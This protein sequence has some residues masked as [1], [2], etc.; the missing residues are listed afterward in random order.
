MAG[1]KKRIKT[2]TLIGAAVRELRGAKGFTQET[3][4]ERADLSKN[5]VGS[6]ERGEKEMSTGVLIR[7]ADALGIPASGLLAKA[8]F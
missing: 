6:I 5:Y 4:A 2:N 7:V 3:L 1:F 8:G